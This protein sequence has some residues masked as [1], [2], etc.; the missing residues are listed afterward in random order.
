M[1]LATNNWKINQ[2]I[3][4][5]EEVY[6]EFNDV[7]SLFDQ[8]ISFDVH[9][10]NKTVFTDLS[11]NNNH[12]VHNGSVIPEVSSRGIKV[13]SGVRYDLTNSFVF[14]YQSEV[15]VFG[16]VEVQGTPN[17]MW[18]YPQNSSFGA[19]EGYQGASASFYTPLNGTALYTTSAG[20]ALVTKDI[21]FTVIKDEVK[22]VWRNGILVGTDNTP[23]GSTA[24]G[25]I[26]GVFKYYS[27]NEVYL[28]QLGIIRTVS[29]TIS[30]INLIGAYLSTKHNV[31]WTNIET[32]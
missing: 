9:N 6:K 14:N 8:Y 1:K 22:K 32:I 12:A 10:V 21:I 19:V 3:Y 4:D 25:T 15:Y 5:A 28:S 18:A 17:N 7:V 26:D 11:G 20:G 29:P 30:N 23:T 2:P 13:E 31:S 27:G 24:N 16:V